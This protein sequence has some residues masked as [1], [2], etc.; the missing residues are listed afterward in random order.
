MFRDWPSV[1]AM[2]MVLSIGIG[3]FTQLALRTTSCSKA[4]PHAVAS[5]PTSRMFPSTE[6]EPLLVDVGKS[7]PVLSPFMRTAIINGLSGLQ[8]LVAVSASCDTG[9]CSFPSYGSITH[10]TLGIESMCVDVSPF[11]IQTDNSTISSG[12]GSNAFMYR[13]NDTLV[14]T[15][16]TFPEGQASISYLAEGDEPAGL[17]RWYPLF[18]FGQEIGW[19][20][21][22]YMTPPG[23][24]EK[25]GISP[26]LS[27]QEKDLVKRSFYSK[28]F[29]IPTLSPCVER[30]A[31]PLTGDP[32]PLI[33]TSS[34]PQLG[35]TNVSTFPG[36]FT[37][38]AVQCHLYPSIRH[39]AGSIVNGRIQ[40]KLIGDP[41]PLNSGTNDTD[42]PGS[43]L[44]HHDL[45]YY[46]FLDPC[47]IQGTVY[48]N[49]NISQAPG[50]RITVGWFGYGKITGPVLCLYG[51]SGGSMYALTETLDLFAFKLL[52]DN[53]WEGCIP[54]VDYTSMEC[55]TRWWLEP[56]LNGGNASFES[57]S[58]VMSRMADA[59]TNQLRMNGTDFFGSPSNVTGT[60]FQTVV[61]TQFQWG[62]L[63]FPAVMVLASAVLLVATAWRSSSRWGRVR[64][65]RGGS[66]VE[67]PVW[68]SSLL[69][70]LFYGLE[71]GARL[72]GAPVEDKE[73]SGLAGEIMARLSLEQGELRFRSARPAP[74]ERKA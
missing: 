72:R 51:A 23:Y 31:Y 41:V 57:I 35:M 37:L 15:N 12:H 74:R 24:I 32:L 45:M 65:N 10:S 20:P 56:L 1:S 39:Y 64:N 49:A 43:A 30:S 66:Q 8:S 69:P 4:V 25:H 36:H 48:T 54:N 29:I 71:D 40:E 19:M 33:N 60:A 38:A 34:C 70:L 16:Y 17:G 18:S 63:L 14:W 7:T 67:V 28:T 52:E 46:A 50:D 58:A 59:I 42:T 73:M 68:K 2:F 55:L 22:T 26:S 13:S 53:S 9:N 3:T 6:F 62:W 11:L 44:T 27:P 21:P 61:C 47:I 5:I